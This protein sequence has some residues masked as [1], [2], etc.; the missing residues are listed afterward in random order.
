MPMASAAAPAMLAPTP[1]PATPATPAAPAP[2]P[3]TPSLP[4]LPRTQRPVSFEE[5]A[6][7]RA[8][9][10]S[11]S[12]VVNDEPLWAVL[13]VAEGAEPPAIKAAF[14]AAAKKY[15]PDRVVAMG[16]P[17]LKE[18]ADRIFRRVNEAHAVLSDPARREEYLAEQKSR[19]AGGDKLMKEKEM[20][21]RVVNAELA[22]SR[23]MV[24]LR[25]RDF[26]AASKEFDEALRLNPEEGEHVGYAFWSRYCVNPEVADLAVLQRELNRAIRLSPKVG[27]LYYFLGVVLKNMDNEDRALLS[28]A[29]ALEVDDRIDEARS[30]IRLIQARREKNKKAPTA[31]AAGKPSSS[32]KEV[33]RKGLFDRLRGK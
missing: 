6:L 31:A 11:K 19:Q 3:R 30:E 17:A 25:K 27:R 12:K 22:F 29:K 5:I 9:I 8:D 10:E 1:A 33:P 26:T 15:H 16:L 28:F 20:A 14:L 23:G 13:G 2:T 32:S 24:F 4:N 18:A 21:V 7:L